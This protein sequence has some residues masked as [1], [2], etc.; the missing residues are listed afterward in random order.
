MLVVQLAGAK[1]GEVVDMPMPLA[2]RLLAAG[3]VGD[4][5]HKTQIG[6]CQVPAFDNRLA[7]SIHDPAHA[8]RPQTAPQP[9]PRAKRAGRQ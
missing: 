5:R 1:A 8:E 2:R 7:D 6:D 4:A 3:R 9:Q